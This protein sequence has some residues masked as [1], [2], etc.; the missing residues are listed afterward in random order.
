[1]SII[2]T[3]LYDKEKRPFYP[4]VNLKTIN[5]QSLLS[6]SEEVEDIKIGGGSS[7][8]VEYGYSSVSV[9]LEDDINTPTYV[10]SIDNVPVWKNYIFK[11]ESYE[12][13]SK[14]PYLWM[15]SKVSENDYV[16]VYT[17]TDSG[18]DIEI[19]KGEISYIYV[20]GNNK[21]VNEK[22]QDL[23]VHI[24]FNVYYNNELV[25]LLESNINIDNNKICQEFLDNFNGQFIQYI[26]DE[27]D[28]IVGLELTLT[29]KK[30]RDTNYN[31]N[32]N[33][34]I[35]VNGKVAYLRPTI[36]SARS[37]AVDTNIVTIDLSNDFDQLY[38]EGNVCVVEQT[39]N[40]KA[41]LYVGNNI[42]D[43]TLYEISTLESGV[44]I[45]DRIVRESVNGVD[46]S[47]LSINVTAQNGATIN[48]KKIEV[49]I[50]IKDVDSN[51]TKN[52]KFG[53]MRV[54]SNTDYDLVVTPTSIIVDRNG[55]YY[56]NNIKIGVKESSIGS[57]YNNIKYEV[58]NGLKIAYVKDGSFYKILPNKELNIE[59]S[60]MPLRSAEFYL[61]K[62]DEERYN[63]NFLDYVN[64]DCLYDANE[65]IVYDLILPYSQLFMDDNG[66]INDD[67]IEITINKSIGNEIVSYRNFDENELEGIFV[68]TSCVC[69]A[70]NE[71]FDTV[72]TSFFFENGK[73]M[74][75]S[76]QEIIKDKDINLLEGINVK[77]MHTYNIDGATEYFTLDVDGI[78]VNKA[79]K[80]SLIV[81]FT[82]D[83]S[84]FRINE[85]NKTLESNVVEV[86]VTLL[87]TDGKKEVIDNISIIDT[88]DIKDWY[89]IDDN[90]NISEN[91][92][93]VII[94]I[95]GEK[96]IGNNEI[97]KFTF[98]IT[99]SDGNKEI[100][101]FSLIPTI[102]NCYYQVEVIPSYIS[103]D[104]EGNVK[105]NDG[106][107]VANVYK[108]EG[109]NITNINEELQ[110]YGMKVIYHY[111]NDD[112][113]IAPSYSQVTNDTYVKL[114]KNDK[115]IHRQYIE[116]TRDGSNG[117]N[118]VSKFKSTVFTRNNNEPD[119]PNGGDYK[120][121]YPTDKDNQGKNIWEDGIPD[122]ESILWASTRTFS[123]DGNHDAS[124][125]DVRQM[126]DTTNFDVEYSSKK[127]P[128]P[129]INHPNTN[130][131]WSNDTVNAIWM[132][133][134]ICENG[135]WSDW[136]VSKIKGENGDDGASYY[137]KYYYIV[138]TGEEVPNLGDKDWS[139]KFPTLLD[140]N[141]V[142]WVKSELWVKTN[143]SDKKVDGVEPDGPIR[144]TGPKGE[145]GES[146]SST[147]KI[148]YPAGIFAANVVYK[149][150]DTTTP[151]VLYNKEYYILNVDN[152]KST[153][154]LSN[155]PVKDTSSWTKMDSF[156]AIYTDVALIQRGRVGEAV[157]YNDYMY[158]ANGV[159]GNS[160]YDSFSP[161]NGTTKK[162]I[163]TIIKD[164]YRP[165]YLVDLNTGEGYYAGGVIRFNKNSAKLGNF[166]VDENGF[167]YAEQGS[168]GYEKN[169]NKD[170]SVC[171]LRTYCPYATTINVNLKNGK[172]PYGTYPLEGR[173]NAKKDTTVKFDNS[174]KQ[175]FVV[176]DNN[177]LTY[178]TEPKGESDY[179]VKVIN[180]IKYVN[181][182]T[183]TELVK[184]TLIFNVS[185]V[186]L[187]QIYMEGDDLR[188]SISCYSGNDIKT[189][190]YSDQNA[191]LTY[192]GNSKY[193]IELQLS[194]AIGYFDLS[195]KGKN[196][197]WLYP[198]IFNGLEKFIPNEL[199]V[200]EVTERIEDFN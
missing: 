162:N 145:P 76:I 79:A 113:I 26:K 166:I 121:P 73:E 185:N 17:G 149:Q 60:D 144:F 191:M 29:G 181:A 25:S 117:T 83:M 129:P 136:V 75:I 62:E 101:I 184:Y 41:Y 102:E 82:P 112:A 16:Y 175:R 100:K 141:D 88:N 95:I 142:V 43:I 120:S 107:I 165:S 64:V 48:S 116:I 74:N 156:K 10:Y 3:Q 13:K 140:S 192:N 158:S 89:S 157:F 150:T 193:L 146:I 143:N 197:G 1:M 148:P 167:T 58:P 81:D 115:E 72:D 49:L 177:V 69:L 77:L 109:A 5:G 78:K 173:I 168:W 155:N 125:S 80:N 190:F 96:N 87:R 182:N 118:G 70:G 28:Y 160:I 34:S 122:G 170:A 169:M 45:E 119:R 180:N 188:C 161:Y 111:N 194:K 137:T 195:L 124:W 199:N 127:N 42:K 40:T 8:N 23:L 186:V 108:Y 131:E 67:N 19:T 21:F 24:L 171:S 104:S 151:Y 55:E 110:D 50:K 7:N 84:Y 178:L 94:N 114:Y 68:K 90:Y 35:N 30:V 33:I 37:G 6:D 123:S 174:A 152:Y 61:C 91:T 128:N 106:S 27:N 163:D 126:T 176:D 71:Q 99:T 11:I 47:V 103:F 46:A 189:L 196:N 132:A 59:G 66:N 153:N 9:G 187:S 4:E 22:N 147:S 31:F 133:T 198:S 14:Y 93:K 51:I 36:I 200:M 183:G 15:R 179:T 38:C 52:A 12:D 135:E 97:K 159:N 98:E 54:N 139:E 56:Q 154:I 130:E 164:A 32:N 18:L 20:D 172:V 86:D 105:G 53:I 63:E 65:T 39:L 92:A 57:V 134:S 85:S 138:K 2:R 44:I